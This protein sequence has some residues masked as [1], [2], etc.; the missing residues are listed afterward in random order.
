MAVPTLEARPRTEFVTI[1]GKSGWAQLDKPDTK[2]N[3]DGKWTQ[4]IYPNAESL[5][6][7]NKL[8]EK[9]IKNKLN[10]DDDGYYI[11]FHRPTQKAYMGRWKALEPPMIEDQ[12]G[13]PLPRTTR[14]GFGS[15]ITVTVEVYYSRPRPSADYVASARL[16][17]VRLD[18]IVPYTRA[19]Y[20]DK[21]LRAV[22]SLDKVPPPTTDGW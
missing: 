1:Q 4:K 14:F 15:D 21:E 20:S 19:E 3:P 16:A 11:S 8:I 12:N 17:V 9:G 18:N 10:K 7:V 13:N 6:K 5:E 22:K 2:F